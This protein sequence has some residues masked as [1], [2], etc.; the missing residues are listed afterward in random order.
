M[1]IWTYISILYSSTW[2]TLTNETKFQTKS[3][4]HELAALTLNKAMNHSTKTLHKQ[5]Y[6]IY[7]DLTLLW[8][9]LYW[10]NLY[11]YGIHNQSVLLIDQK[12]RNQKTVCEWNKV[13]MG[14]I[15]DECGILK[16]GKNSSEF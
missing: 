1:A 5:A 3:S 8:K 12:L 7:L 15:K 14:P 6:G 2:D 13:L 10:Y 9:N 4:S 11:D 16:G